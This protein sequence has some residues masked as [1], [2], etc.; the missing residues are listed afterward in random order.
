[1]VKMVPRTFAGGS[2]IRMS[3]EH[4]W[5]CHMTSVSSKMEEFA[6]I[7]YCWL[8]PN[9]TRK[10]WDKLLLEVLCWLTSKLKCIVSMSWH[11]YLRWC[12][13]AMCGSGVQ[14]TCGR[15]E[16][17]FPT[18]VLLPVIWGCFHSTHSSKALADAD[19][20]LTVEN[21]HFN[22]VNLR[23]GRVDTH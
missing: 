9:P 6:S 4:F 2:L 21:F 15:L 7:I 17:I 23:I 19:S 8:F 16:N 20:V 1:M 10:L 22:F 11:S 12:V 14:R 18:R 5:A 3:Y 13:L